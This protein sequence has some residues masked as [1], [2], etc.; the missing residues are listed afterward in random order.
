VNQWDTCENRLSA[1]DGWQGKAKHQLTLLTQFAIAINAALFV[2][3]R[4]TTVVS[5]A[6]WIFNPTNGP[7][8]SKKMEK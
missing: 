4:G 2:L 3:G 1:R 7:A 6:I 8:Q 5:Q